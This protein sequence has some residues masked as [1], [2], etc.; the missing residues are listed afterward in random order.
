MLSKC[1]QVV[2]EFPFSAETFFR[3]SKRSLYL[4]SSELQITKTVTLAPSEA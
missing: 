3:T 1:G 2:M 4:I